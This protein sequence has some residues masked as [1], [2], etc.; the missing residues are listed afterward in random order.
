MKGKATLILGMA[1]GYVLGTRDGRERYEQI[2]SQANRLWNDP[3][4]QHKA[5]QAQDVLKEKAPKVQE[6]VSQVAH[7]AGDKVTGGSDSDLPSSDPTLDPT[8]PVVGSP[9]MPAAPTDVIIPPSD[10]EG[11]IHG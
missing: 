2:K 5:S 1:A 3:K 9:S 11:G 7:K 6:K 4:V 10:Q 8:T